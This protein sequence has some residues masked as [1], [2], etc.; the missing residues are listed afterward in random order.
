MDLDPDELGFSSTFRLT[1]GYV[2]PKF[3]RDFERFV[4]QSV[5]KS[6]P[7]FCCLP[8]VGSIDKVLSWCL[9]LAAITLPKTNIAP[10]ED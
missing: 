3:P 2:D 6:P 8:I 5:N 1:P 9:A 7:H 4:G 10:V